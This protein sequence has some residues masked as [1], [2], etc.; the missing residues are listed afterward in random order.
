MCHQNCNWQI[1]SPKL[2][3][4]NIIVFIY[5]NSMF[6]IHLEFEGGCYSL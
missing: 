6:L 5:S 2:R 3:L 1:S 4:E